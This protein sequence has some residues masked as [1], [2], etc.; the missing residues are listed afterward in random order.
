MAR[1]V[2]AYS[3]QASGQAFPTTV[4]LSLTLF[5][6]YVLLF[7]FHKSHTV[8]I[9]VAHVCKLNGQSK[10]VHYIAMVYTIYPF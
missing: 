8:L 3:V 1:T 5:Q 7:D 6:Y 9:L 4:R 2:L 10:A